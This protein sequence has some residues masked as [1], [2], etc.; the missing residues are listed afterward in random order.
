MVWRNDDIKIEPSRSRK[1]TALP[2][3]SAGKANAA[4]LTRLSPCGNHAVMMLVETA[5]ALVEMWIRPAAT[6]TP[7]INM[8]QLIDETLCRTDGS[9]SCEPPNGGASHGN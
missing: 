7:S 5:R 4:A 8:H 2:H 1:L 9:I 6:L 3:I